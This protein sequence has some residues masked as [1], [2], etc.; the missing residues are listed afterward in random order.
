M[1]FHSNRFASVNTYY[2]KNLSDYKVHAYNHHNY[3][4][5]CSCGCDPRVYSVY[6]TAGLGG[7]N[8]L[9]KAWR[10]SWRAVGLTHKRS[11]LQI[12]VKDGT[13]RGSI[14]IGVLESKSEALSS[15]AFMSAFSQKVLLTLGEGLPLQLNIPGNHAYPS[16]T[17]PFSGFN[18]IDNQ[19]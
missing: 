15:D 16:R 7:S 6:E 19:N 11:C 3:K 2:Q 10:N 17:M 12:L 1:A 13:G 18:K 9:L 4:N 5:T 14:S 8:I